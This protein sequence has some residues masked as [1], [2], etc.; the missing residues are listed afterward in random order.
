MVPVKGNPV[1][2]ADYI[3]RAFRVVHEQIRVA[4][5][6]T[7][8]ELVNIPPDEGA[9][10][11]A[12]LVTHALGAEAETISSVAGREVVRD[13][14]TE[15]MARCTLDDLHQ[16]LDA[17]DKR[18]N[19]LLPDLLAC[20]L[21]EKCSLPTKDPTDQHP[22]AAWLLRN[23]GHAHEHYGQILLTKERVMRLHRPDVDPHP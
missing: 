21:E 4:L 19:D 18:L 13:R 16:L 1:S 14:P 15:F 9:N 6:D 7:D 5:K 3:Y 8:D 10:T 20:N 12:V 17:S 11:I 23:L 22:R 2:M